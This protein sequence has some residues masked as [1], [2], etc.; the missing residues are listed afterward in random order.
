[1]LEVPA[2]DGPTAAQ[3]GHGHVQGIRVPSRAYDPRAEISLS[4]R[5]RV[6]IDLHA[7]N[8][9][10]QFLEKAPHAFGS[11][12]THASS[13]RPTSPIFRLACSYCLWGKKANLCERRSRIPQRSVS[14][15]RTVT[16]TP[17]AGTTF[18]GFRPC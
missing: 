17:Q 13:M 7:L 15:N 9:R 12:F 6:I 8:K 5:V 18:L 14:R 1:M 10:R 2:Y 4:K 3:G 11:A 16:S